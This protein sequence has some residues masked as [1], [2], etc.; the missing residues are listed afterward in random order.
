VIVVVTG[1]FGR[2][3]GE[4]RTMEFVSVS[5]APD[6]GSGVPGPGAG[7]GAVTAAGVRKDTMVENGLLCPGSRPRARQKNRVPAVRFDPIVK[8]VCDDVSGTDAVATMFVMFA[9]LATWKT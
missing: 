5:L 1:Q 6:G 9:S 4:F 2:S 7:D 3:N 8:V